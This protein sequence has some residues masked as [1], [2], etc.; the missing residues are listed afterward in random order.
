MVDYGTTIRIKEDVKK[1]L[2][3]V[4]NELHCKTI[5]D[6]IRKL[7]EVYNQKEILRTGDGTDW[8]GLLTE[9]MR[10]DNALGLYELFYPD[11]SRGQ[12]HKDIDAYFYIENSV[13]SVLLAMLDKDFMKEL[14]RK[15]AH[16]PGE[17][18]KLIKPRVNDLLTKYRL[19]ITIAWLLATQ[20]KPNSQD[21]RVQDI[22]NILKQTIHMK[23]SEAEALF[24]NGIE[25]NTRNVN[26]QRDP[27]LEELAV[28][29]IKAHEHS[30][31][32]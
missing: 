23:K 21:Q 16:A 17:L 9:F 14:Y 12:F 30:F 26:G 20:T 27:K 19:E 5:D 24:K 13:K 6:V 1:S 32:R 7:V 29:M 4:K 2:E 15:M 25:D 18:P 10:I 8:K 11:S 31:R 22:F 3:V 28:K